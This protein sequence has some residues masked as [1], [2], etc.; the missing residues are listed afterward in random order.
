MGSE[1]DRRLNRLVNRYSADPEAL[2]EIAAHY[3]TTGSLQSPLVTVHTTD[4]PIIPYWHEKLYRL[5]AAAA[6]SGSLHK[7]IPISRYGH[8]SFKASEAL[9][10]FVLLFFKVK[11][12]RPFVPDAVLRDSN[13][14]TEFW[15]LMTKHGPAE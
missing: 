8:C 6:G 12:Q 10:G 14:V 3:Q 5:K 15:D 7:N 13:T 9:A 11:G 1:N 4:D 2:D